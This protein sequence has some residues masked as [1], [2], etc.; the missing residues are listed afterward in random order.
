ML[1]TKHSMRAVARALQVD[2]STISREVTRADTLDLPHYHAHLGQRVR[3]AR[4]KDAGRKR[5]KLGADTDSACWKHV[6]AGLHGGW[7]PQQIAGRSRLMQSRC[8]PSMPCA[9]SVS[10]E[11]IYCAIYAQPRGALRT[12]LV[13][14]LR[15]SH[16]GRLPRARGSARFTGLQGMTPIALRP[17]EVAARIVPGHWEGDLIKGAAN[18]SAVGTIVERTS[19]F[20]LLVKLDS[21]GALDVLNGFSRRL[22]SVPPSL[23]KTMTYDQ[24]T[25]MALHA[26]LAKQLH[27]DIF[28]CDPHSPW[29]RGTN[30]NSN[31]MIREYLP[32]GTDLSAFSYQQLTSI[33]YSLNNRPRAVLGFRTPAEVFSELKLNY[34]AGVALQA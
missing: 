3:A 18:Q 28:F 24:G 17:A 27:I 9:V 22:R 20:I 6:I 4:R 29:Q 34:I 21:A 19:R 25:E 11:T 30:E 10:H 2:V 23:R 15:K 5:R 8:D 32:K 31:G 33:E 14:L 26:D 7:S 16:A 13:S 1:R 12:E